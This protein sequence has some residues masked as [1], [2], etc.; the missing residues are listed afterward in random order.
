MLYCHDPENRAV[1]VISGK[2]K[3]ETMNEEREEKGHFADEDEGILEA[4][5]E[6]VRENTLLAFGVLFA[7]GFLILC[8][9]AL[10]VTI[11]GGQGDDAPVAAAGTE[12]GDDVPEG[13][14]PTG[15]MPGTGE[16]GQAAE[17]DD[18]A[19]PAAPLH[20]DAEVY[21]ASGHFRLIP[22]SKNPEFIRVTGCRSDRFA[23]YDLLDCRFEEVEGKG[24]ILDDC[25]VVG[26]YDPNKEA[27]DS[28]ASK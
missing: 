16:M 7:A 12:A 13:F 10:S 15:T 18:P 19:E 23:F 8:G 5:K 4:I 1:A 14:E 21:E 11:F 9:G 3:E 2:I 26:T 20:C 6:W 27:A 17:S 28:V 24:R 22:D 25:T